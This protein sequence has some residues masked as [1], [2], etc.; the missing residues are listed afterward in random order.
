MSYI[1]A[2]LKETEAMGLGPDNPA[3]FNIGSGGP[4]D[5]TSTS[6]AGIFDRGTRLKHPLVWIDLEMTGLNPLEDKIMEI[7]C[8]VT[9]GLLNQELEGPELAIRLN[10]D[11]IL[12][13]ND[14]CQEHHHSSGL[15]QR[16][17]ESNV[18]LEE[19]EEQ[20]LGFV[21]RCVP[22]AGQALLA[23]NSVHNDLSFLRVH[24]PRLAAHLS[25]RICDVTTVVELSK[26]WYPKQWMN[27]PRKKNAH[28]AMSDIKE[29][30][31]ELK[32]YQQQVFRRKPK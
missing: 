25:Y 2:L 4:E 11:D 32:Y 21:R 29:S 22:N 23:G 28:T 1:T 27:A 15:V 7:A 24:M 5:G 19:A 14:W 16:C 9:D 3:D 18:S 26:R 30:I 13:M 6:D 17:R 10:E 12:A 20:V 31:K 8:V